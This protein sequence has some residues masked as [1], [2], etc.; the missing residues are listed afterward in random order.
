MPFL[1]ILAIV[2]IG[3]F[4]IV[5][6]GMPIAPSTAVQ[7][8]SKGIAKAEGF[9]VQGSIAQRANNPGDLERGDIGYGTISGKTIYPSAGQGWNALYVQVQAMLNGTSA[10]YNPSMSISEIAPIYTGNDNATAWAQN[11]ADSVGVDPDTQIGQ[12]T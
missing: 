11:V 8:I 4:L 10:Y 6:G 3:A 9:Y 1:I 12:I 7:K 5:E 2:G